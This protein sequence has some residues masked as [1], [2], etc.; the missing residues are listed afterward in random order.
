VKRYE[1]IDHPSDLGILAYGEEF[2]ETLENSAYGMFSMMADLKSV[3]PVRS[4]E[5]AAVG[6]TAE[7]FLV[8]W[9]NELLH[10]FDSKRLLLSSFN[11]TEL[12]LPDDFA[13]V[14]PFTGKLP[15]KKK[16]A[17][18]A[19]P[20]QTGFSLTAQVRG[21]SAEPSN[22]LRSIKAVT[23]NQL[24]ATPKKIRVVFDV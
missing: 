8:N 9:L 12:S 22:L 6:D 14:R 19:K 4:L 7:E 11:I 15:S 3:K 16:N 18:L 5:V 13:G 21:S 24:L 20:A 23:H 10:I 1:E 2:K 17:S